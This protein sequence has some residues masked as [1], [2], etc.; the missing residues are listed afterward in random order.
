M[1]CE[2]LSS[3]ALPSSLSGGRCFRGT[4]R[5]S[6]FDGIVIARSEAASLAMTALVPSN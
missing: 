1:R 6:R 4:Q 3:A 5:T 2:T